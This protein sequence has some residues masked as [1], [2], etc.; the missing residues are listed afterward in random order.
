MGR[1]V[2]CVLGR[3][4]AA[5]LIVVGQCATAWANPQGGTVRAG[6]ATITTTPGRTEI[7]QTSDRVIIDWQGFSIGANELTRFNQPSSGSAALNRVTGG[8]PSKILGQ[9]QANGKILLINPNGILFGAGSKVDVAGLVATTANIA[10][11]DFMAKRLSFS[12]PG[13]GNAAVV[14]RGT[15][16]VKEGGLVALVAPGVANE[17]VITARLG[18]VSLVSANRFTVDFHGDRLIQFAV[19]D[20]VTRQAVAADGTKLA[21]AVSNSGRIAANGGVVQMSANV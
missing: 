8:D 20:K 1:G 15:I 11:D 18:K 5:G 21:A 14:N 7:N 4:F 16:T 13:N 3:V 9:L 6:G 12:Q 10:N 17:G 2:P 19:D